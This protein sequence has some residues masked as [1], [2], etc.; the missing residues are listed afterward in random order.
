M[1]VVFTDVAEAE[2]IEIGAH[3]A[4]DSPRN[5]EAFVKKLLDKT[6]QI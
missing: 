3:I 5:A 2:L 4:E 6:T 1:S